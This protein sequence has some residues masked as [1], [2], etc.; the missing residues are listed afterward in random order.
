MTDAITAVGL[1]AASTISGI[2]ALYAARSE[3]N[4]RPVSNGF[5]EGIRADVREI[6]TL[7]IEHIKDHK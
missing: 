1:I 7:M 5:A 4:S 6:R 3:K 2:A